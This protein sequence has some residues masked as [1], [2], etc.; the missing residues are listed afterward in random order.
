MAGQDDLAK[1]ALHELYRVQPNIS[2]AW[3]SGQL[4]IKQ[5]R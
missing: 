1:F 3:I 4:P 2:L 5:G